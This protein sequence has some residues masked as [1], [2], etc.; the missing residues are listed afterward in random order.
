MN[1]EILLLQLDDDGDCGGGLDEQKHSAILLLF[2]FC[3]S[4][5]C[6]S[7]ALYGK[8]LPLYKAIKLHQVFIF[9]ILFL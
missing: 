1:L 2:C 5:F 3:S 4:N 7:F 9:Y 8:Y 6:F